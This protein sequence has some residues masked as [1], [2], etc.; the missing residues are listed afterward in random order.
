MKYPFFRRAFT[1][2][3]PTENI[4]LD[5]LDR[6]EEPIDEPKE[7]LKEESKEESKEEDRKE[8]VLV[9]TEKVYKVKIKSRYI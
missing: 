5:E 8:E 3:K 1:P 2:P 4:D 7:E 6:K 9:T